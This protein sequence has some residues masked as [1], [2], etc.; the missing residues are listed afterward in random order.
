[1]RTCGGA[2]SR[3]NTHAGLIDSVWLVCALSRLGV[4]ANSLT[5]PSLLQAK[6]HVEDKTF[7]LKNK[8]KSKKVQVRKN[9][10]TVRA[11]LC[12]CIADADCLFSL[13]NLRCVRQTFVKSVEAQAKDIVS[14]AAIF[15]RAR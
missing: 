9:K 10:D 12:I 7:G 14:L 15:S 13:D 11:T 2:R 4:S 3:G 8:N 6:K 5:R 1:M